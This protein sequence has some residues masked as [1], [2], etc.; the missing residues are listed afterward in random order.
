ML[1][2]AAYKTEKAGKTGLNSSPPCRTILDHGRA[3]DKGPVDPD[4]YRDEERDGALAKSQ[5]SLS[6]LNR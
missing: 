1:C 3:T 2:S 6:E 4:S 5:C